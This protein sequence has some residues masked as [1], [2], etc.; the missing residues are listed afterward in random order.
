MIRRLLALALLVAAPFAVAQAPL[1]GAVE[2]ASAG[3]SPADPGPLATDV[4]PALTH[5]AI[6]GA[7]KKV[8][9]WQL[10]FAGLTG[11]K[12]PRF[13]Q[14]W[15]YAPLYDGLLAYSRATGDPSG[16][17]AVLHAAESFHWQLIESRFPHA[18]DEAIGHAYLDL[19]MEKKSEERLAATQAVMDRLVARADETKPVWWWCDALYM[20]PPTLVRLAK[21]TGDHKYI[22]YMNHE[23]KVTTDL[24]YDKDEH[25]YFRDDRFL[26]FAKQHEANGKHIFWSRGDGWVVAGTGQP[27]GVSAGERPRACRI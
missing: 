4:S 22:D 8:V 15:T 5:K 25:L 16:H 10:P 24:L 1:S 26:D 14:Q 6:R 19:Y 7:M 23:W 18:D 21:V 11:S 27:A 2:R 9:D 20:A 13:N 12:T 3:D 17:D